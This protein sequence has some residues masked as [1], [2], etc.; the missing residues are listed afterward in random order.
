[1]PVLIGIGIILFI[2]IA[3][4][5]GFYI[6]IAHPRLVSHDDALKI[7]ESKDFLKD[8]PSFKK[9]VL[10]I[11]ARDG[12]ELHGIY[13][14][15]E[16]SDKTVIITHG[17]TYNYEGS[18]KYANVFHALGF[19]VYMYDIRHHGYNKRT[20]C[21]MGYKESRDVE[22]VYKYFR[23]KVGNE[24]I[25]GLHGE[26]LGAASSILALA[27]IKDADFLVADCG[28]ADFNELA[29]HLAKNGMHLPAFLVK[30]PVILCLIL[31]GFRLDRI[32]PID[33][34]SK[35]NSTPVLFI[36]GKIDNFIPK[37]H[38]ERMY[39]ACRSTK[40]L[41]IFDNAN[42]AESYYVNP[43]RYMEE[44]SAFLKDIGII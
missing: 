34:L 16:S 37:S 18:I 41:C 30:L 21:S 42:H 33:A 23:N 8:F 31:H 28:F 38:S 24:E 3:A 35:N 25:L 1:M 20:Y 44:T 39:E 36:H 32:R 40:R 5:I 11:K 4:A 27:N 22:D 15:C 7:E 43:D 9:E 26:S 13:V 17:Y 10:N 6:F 12:Y 2:I 29:K 19:N 14:P